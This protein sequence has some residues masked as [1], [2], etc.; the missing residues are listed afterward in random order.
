MNTILNPDRDTIKREADANYYEQPAA[1]Y[2]LE[3][4]LLRSE[5]KE[6]QSGDL[7]GS[8]DA[9]HLA[10]IILVHHFRDWYSSVAIKMGRQQ[11]ATKEPI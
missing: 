2:C 6:I 5:L 7:L 10:T 3:T 9:Q 4:D 8:G 1:D 11:G